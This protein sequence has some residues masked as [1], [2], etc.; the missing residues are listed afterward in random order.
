[1]RGGCGGRA[2]AHAAP[3]IMQEVSRVGRRSSDVFHFSGGLHDVQKVDPIHEPPPE[4]VEHHHGDIATTAHFHLLVQR[5]VVTLFIIRPL[6]PA[7]DLHPLIRTALLLVLLLDTLEQ[8]PPAI[9]VILY[10]DAGGAT[11]R[12]CLGRLGRRRV[13]LRSA[14]GTSYAACELARDE[15]GVVDEWPREL[16]VRVSIAVCDGE[17]E[18]FDAEHKVAHPYCDLAGAPGVDQLPLLRFNHSHILKRCDGH[19]LPEGEEHQPLDAEELRKGSDVD[20]LVVYG[21]VEEDQ[22]VHGPDLREVLEQGQP[23]VHRLEG[24]AALLVHSE[25]PRHERHDGREDGYGD[26]LQHPAETH[27]EELSTHV[28]VAQEPSEGDEV[29]RGVAL[30]L[31]QTGQILRPAQVG[32]HEL[33]EGKQYERL[34]ELADYREHLCPVSVR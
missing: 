19:R 24:E 23:R 30:L 15:P 25:R 21:V 5:H 8:H 6:H 28:P 26:V 32:Q 20:E 9:V 17:S 31:E 11:R 12:P 22:R 7:V 10:V 16:I 3:D 2:A 18:H 29:C 4:C 13:Y 34:V 1:M 33:Q 14:K 27:G